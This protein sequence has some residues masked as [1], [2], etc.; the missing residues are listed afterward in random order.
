MGAAAK[1]EPRL[2]RSVSG[3][4]RLSC[5]A[6]RG[7]GRSEQQKGNSSPK[8]LRKAKRSSY[9]SSHL[10]FHGDEALNCFDTLLQSLHPGGPDGTLFKS[11]GKEPIGGVWCF[12]ATLAIAASTLI[13]C[14]A[15]C[16]ASF[17]VLFRGLPVQ[18]GAVTS[19]T[20]RPTWLWNALKFTQPTQ[21]AVGWRLAG[22]TS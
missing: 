20:S 2:S 4:R 5:E 17:L 12:C 10:C 7:E 13:S 1:Q 22:R 19:R 9:P 15:C 11:F 8:H 3:F 6:R 18:L 21:N 16:R 14:A